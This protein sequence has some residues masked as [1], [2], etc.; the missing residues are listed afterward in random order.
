MHRPSPA[1]AVLPLTGRFVYDPSMAK[2]AAEIRVGRLLEVRV[3]KGYESVAD[4]DDMIA[5]IRAA[6]SHLLPEVKHVTFADWRACR[7]MRPEAVERARQMLVGTNPRTER[8]AVIVLRDSPTAVMQFF[9][10]VAEA[11]NPTRRIFHD[12]GALGDWLAEVLTPEETARLRS[13]LAALP[14]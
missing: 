13:V 14:L 4:V 5:M 2:N 11:E 7:V 12:V 6:V 9:R 10:I 1:V 3:G 8:S